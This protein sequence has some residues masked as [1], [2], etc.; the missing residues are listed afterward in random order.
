MTKPIYSLILLCFKHLIH[1][2]LSRRRFQGKL[3]SD[4]QTG[5]KSKLNTLMATIQD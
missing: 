4:S 5:L 2:T 3:K 1:H